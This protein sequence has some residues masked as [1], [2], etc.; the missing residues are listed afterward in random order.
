MHTL[1]KGQTLINII[2]VDQQGLFRAGMQH[3]ISR[4]SEVHLM[5]NVETGKELLNAIDKQQDTIILL[6]TNLQDMSMISL[7][8]KLRRN[9]NRIKLL[10]LADDLNMILAKQYLLAGADGFIVKTVSEHQFLEALKKLSQNKPVMPEALAQ[11]LANKSMG[12]ENASPFEAL[13]E[14]EM[15]ILLLMVKGKSIKAISE[16]LHLSPKTIST[17]KGRIFEKLKVNSMMDVFLLAIE[18]GLIKSEITA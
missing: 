5:A 17:Y 15:D 6:S 10:V 7:I 11:D 4:Y 3:M 14:R 12:D 8:K 18:F 2:L 1:S 16:I 9:Y 13:S